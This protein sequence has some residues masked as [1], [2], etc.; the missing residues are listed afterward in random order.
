MLSQTIIT[1]LHAASYKQKVHWHRMWLIFLFETHRELS[2]MH[3]FNEHFNI[4][5]MEVLFWLERLLWSISLLGNFIL[6]IRELEI[7]ICWY[8]Q[9]IKKNRTYI[10]Y[11]KEKE[12]KILFCPWRTQKVWWNTSAGFWRR[13]GLS[14]IFKFVPLI[15]P[16]SICHSPFHYNLMMLVPYCKSFLE[17]PST[18]R[19]GQNY[20]AWHTHI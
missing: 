10:K 17:L 16:S 20:L 11:T 14:E 15:H 9:C 6:L 8:N 12:K 7:H 3:Y 2:L 18:V 1:C 19:L 13:S 5:Y 4:G